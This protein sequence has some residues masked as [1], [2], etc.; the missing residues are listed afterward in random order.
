MSE[1]RKRRNTGKV[2]LA[3]VAKQAGVGTM[4]VSRVLRTPNAVSDKLRDKVQRAVEQLGYIPNRAAGALA[5]AQ[6]DA[7]A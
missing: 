1:P 6:S 3:D 5:S 7:I 4:T 2:T